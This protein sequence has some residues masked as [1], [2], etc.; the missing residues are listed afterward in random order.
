MRA[1]KFHSWKLAR[2]WSSSQTQGAEE[3]KERFFVVVTVLLW[4]STPRKLPTDKHT[5]LDALE[6]SLLYEGCLNV[7]VSLLN[8]KPSP[9][10]SSAF[11]SWFERCTDTYICDGL[12]RHSL[13][14]SRS[15]EKLHFLGSMKVFSWRWRGTVCSCSLKAGLCTRSEEAEEA[16][17]TRDHG[18]DSADGKH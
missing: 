16:G 14:I 5:R 17:C 8:G 7:F 9:N 13:Q 10:R 3:C 6:R 11:I 12:K 4:L 2:L 15:A 1:T 18:G